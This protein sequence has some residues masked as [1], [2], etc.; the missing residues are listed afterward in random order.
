LKITSEERKKDTEMLELYQERM[1]EMELTSHRAP[2]TLKTET[3]AT[4]PSENNDELTEE[5]LMGD[6]FGLDGE[7]DD[8]ITGTTMTDLKL[9]VKRL[10]RELASVKKNEADASRILVLQNLL[11]DANRMKARYEAD[12]MAAHREK[13]VLQRDLEEIRSGKALGDG[14][15]VLFYTSSR[16][17]SFTGRK[18]RLRYG[19]DLTRRL[20]S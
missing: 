19:N 16:F 20:I 11:E 3:Q 8:A 15:V 7:L 4:E 2:T 6:S 18:L 9:Q 1:R 12:Y 10:Q 17:K 13:L 5:E 14:W